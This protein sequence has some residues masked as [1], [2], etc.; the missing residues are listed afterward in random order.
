[1][2]FANE[3]ITTMIYSLRGFQ[4]MLDSDLANLYGVE[5]GALN[6]QVRRNISRFPSD[7]LIEPTLKELEKALY[8][9]VFYGKWNCHAFKRFK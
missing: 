6:R 9:N 8:P 7:F 2:S 4:V 1:M 3:E 5:T